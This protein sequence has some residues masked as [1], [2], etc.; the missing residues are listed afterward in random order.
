LVEKEKVT[1]SGILLSSADPT[2]ANKGK[3]LKIGPNVLDIKEGD[4]ILP[5]WNKARL[6]KFM[7]NDFYIV[8]EDDVVLIFE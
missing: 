3:V 6:A 7:N 1:S 5:N 4:M 2:E 8:S